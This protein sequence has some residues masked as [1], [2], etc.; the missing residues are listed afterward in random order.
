[1]SNAG[2]KQRIQDE[3]LRRVDK[4]KASFEG[5]SDDEFRAKV[6]EILVA[7]LSEPST[8]IRERVAGG[9]SIRYVVPDAVATYIADHHLYRTA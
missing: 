4:H 8:A 3:L 6:R 9:R 2:S 5:L 1:M 7:I